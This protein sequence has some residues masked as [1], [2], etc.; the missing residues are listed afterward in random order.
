MRKRIITIIFSLLAV[1]A[2]IIFNVFASTSQ[3]ILWEDDFENGLFRFNASTHTVNQHAT[4]AL[5]I[6]SPDFEVFY[7][8]TRHPGQIIIIGEVVGPSINRIIHPR[9]DL[10]DLTQLAAFNHVITPVLVHEIIH[11]GYEVYND[12]RVGDVVDIRELYYFV[13]PITGSHANGI[14]AGQIVAQWGTRPMES[15]HRYL[16]FAH[17]SGNREVSPYHYNGELVLNAMHRADIYRLT[18][19]VPLSGSSHSLPEWHRDA[20]AR[21]GHL[22]HE[23]PAI[24]P[25][26]IIEPRTEDEFNIIIQGTP[27]ATAIYDGDGNRLIH[28]GL[29]LYRET[30]TRGRERVGQRVSLSHAL[31]RYQYI[32]EPGEWIFRDLDFSTTALPASFQVLAFEDYEQVALAYYAD[33]PSSSHLELHVMPSGRTVLTDQVTGAVI[34]PTEVDYEEAETDHTLTI[35]LGGTPNNPTT[36]A[37]IDSIDIPAGVGILAFLSANHPAYHAPNPTRVGY[38]FQGWYMNASFTEPLVPATLMPARAATLYARWER[39]T[40]YRLTINLGGTPSNPTIPATMD[41][42]DI[43]AGANLLAFLAANHP[44]YH[45]PDPTRAGFTFRGWYMNANFTIGLGAYTVMPARDA[46]L[47][48]RWEAVIP[49]NTIQVRSQAE[50]QAAIN[51]LVAQGSN[52]HTTI[53][54]MQDLTTFAA[55]ITIPANVN[56]TLTSSPG[57]VFTYTRQTSGRHFDVN[58]GT[59]TL[60]NVVICG[61][62]ASFNSGGF[63]VRNRGHL[64]MREGSVI[65]NNRGISGGAIAVI[66]QSQL[67]MYD[68]IIEGNRSTNTGGG[69]NVSAATFTMYGGIIRDN[70][71][72]AFGGGIGV[73]GTAGGFG[74]PGTPGIVNI[75]GG[76]IDSNTASLGGGVFLGLGAINI[77]GTSDTAT[78]SNNEA[79]QT[80]GG[81]YFQTGNGTNPMASSFMGGSITNNR[82]GNNGGGIAI[83]SINWMMALSIYDG[84][85]I[86]N[87]EANYGG[88]I[89]L[90]NAPMN[91]GIIRL[92]LR[93]AQILNNRAV[94]D[95][96]GIFTALASNY[97]NPMPVN[98]Y[99]NMI[100]TQATRF[101]GNVAG[102]GS[103]APPSNA[104]AIM[105]RATSVS[106]FNHQI[107]NYDINFGAEVVGIRAFSFAEDALTLSEADLAAIAAF[108]ERY[109]FDFDEIYEYLMESMESV[110]HE[111]MRI[112]LDRY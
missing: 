69:I 24:P 18:P 12:V 30:L 59:L 7:S 6:L 42:I 72:G 111:L 101:Q 39:V 34:P 58:G 98:A 108:A 10:R 90:T 41:S 28:D 73:G 25:T 97:Q 68:G 102:N 9:I 88:G 4:E 62:S 92:E 49:A 1:S 74:A 31:R 78:I 96:G 33:S 93:G 23:L 53:M 26:P 86:N 14:P 8:L 55:T 95:G 3:P 80:G 54:M 82:A 36:P 63:D 89:W 21:F 104:T 105:P 99:G 40:T 37:A 13:T 57:N 60:E 110:R 103:F 84:F 66:G 48:V 22:Y 29:N 61:N 56:I 85:I 46:T 87:N 71:S 38:T 94:Y 81:I 52:Q 106:A 27:I 64:I 43:P 83:S 100:I 32:L 70:Q 77:R 51:N 2:L 109:D 91:V 76:I 15:G 75:Y 20:M 65:R 16:I 112:D 50:L 5:E 11:L 45:A 19:I 44:A 17:N 79:I 107:N 67:T 47:Y 35:N